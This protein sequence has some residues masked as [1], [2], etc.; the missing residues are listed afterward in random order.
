LLLASCA[1]KPAEPLRYTAL[2]PAASASTQSNAFDPSASLTAM[3]SGCRTAELPQPNALDDDCDGSIDS[4]DKD[5]P[6]LIALAFPRVLAQDIALALRS[7][8]NVEVPLVVSDCGEERSVCTVYVDTKNLARG[9]HALL[10]RH[11]DHGAQKGTH[12]LVVSAQTP[13]KVA[14]YLATLAADVTEQSLG[15]VALP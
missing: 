3:T 1:I 6:L 9:R 12:A 8:S 4:F 15:S 5:L 13:G 14:T 10:A 7:E 2:P 11:T